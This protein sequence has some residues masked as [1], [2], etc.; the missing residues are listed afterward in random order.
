MFFASTVL[1]SQKRLNPSCAFRSVVAAI[2][3]LTIVI[4]FS[5][6]GA[7]AH[8]SDSVPHSREVTILSIDAASFDESASRSTFYCDNNAPQ[9]D[10]ACC[11]NTCCSACSTGIVAVGMPIAA[12][13][14]LSIDA[15]PNA[16][17]LPRGIP[18]PELQP[19]RLY[20]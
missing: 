12:R 5:A 10:D 20:Y 9:V 15:L 18:D 13:F 4:F 17:N 19:P 8:Y 16:E 14:L 2:I 11:I 1:R 6:G 3:T 7:Q